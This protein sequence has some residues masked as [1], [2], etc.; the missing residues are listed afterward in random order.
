MKQVGHGYTEVTKM[1]QIARV[2]TLCERVVVCLKK[3]RRIIEG[4]FR[5]T[6]A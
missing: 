6:D 1:K 5:H 4:L 2:N 3:Q